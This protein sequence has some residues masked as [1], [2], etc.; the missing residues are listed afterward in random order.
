M[1]GGETT[2]ELWV[3]AAPHL[4]LSSIH[5]E[6]CRDPQAMCGIVGHDRIELHAPNH[7]QDWWSSQLIVDVEEHDGGSLLRGRFALHPSLWAFGL[8][9]SAVAAFATL[10][11]CSYAY[12]QWAMGQSMT[13]LWALPLVAAT[14]LAW[15]LALRLG[16]KERRTRTRELRGF[17]EAALP[18]PSTK[19]IRS[20]FAG[21]PVV[22]IGTLEQAPAVKPTTA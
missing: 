15:K 9:L 3:E 16:H 11:I 2:L 21:G 1:G 7:R 17:L 5:R 19:S 13:A 10:V 18:C 22:E 4:V 6:L 14:L 12:A 8:G 20:D